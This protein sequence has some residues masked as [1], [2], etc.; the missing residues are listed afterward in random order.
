MTAINL[1]DANP[2]LREVIS[3]FNPGEAAVIVEQGRA[4]AT[5]TRTGSNRRPCKAGSAKDTKHRM[6][7]DFDAPLETHHG[8]TESTESDGC[9]KRRLD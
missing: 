5:L 3:G 6:A 2:R 4:L 1:D 7:D 8:G 9:S